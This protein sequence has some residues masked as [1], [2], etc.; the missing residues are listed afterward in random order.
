[1]NA[2]HDTRRRFSL[3]LR[4]VG[5]LLAVAAS[6]SLAACGSSSSSSSGAASSSSSSTSASG[7]SAA[8]QAGLAKAQAIVTSEIQEPTAITDTVKVTKPIPKGLT[9][10]FIPCGS[11]ECTL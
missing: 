10:D 8:D 6:L 3:R 4:H 1:M 5:V 11:T 7:L 9:V 2:L